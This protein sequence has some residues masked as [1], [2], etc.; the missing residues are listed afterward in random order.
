MVIPSFTS[1]LDCLISLWFGILLVTTAAT[2][3]GYFDCRRPG[4]NLCI[5]NNGVCNTKGACDCPTGWSG[6]M[7]HVDNANISSP[8]IQP[9]SD[10]G[11]CVTE[12]GA[13]V[14]KCN[15][16]RVDILPNCVVL[17]YVV[18]CDSS[19]M[20][21][22]IYPLGVFGG[23]IFV[24]GHQS[25]CQIPSNN[26]LFIFHTDT[27]CGNAISRVEGNK[28]RFS[29]VIYIQYDQA[30]LSSIDEV[31]EVVCVIPGPTVGTVTSVK[32]G[33]LPEGSAVVNGPGTYAVT[34]GGDLNPLRLSVKKGGSQVTD[35]T[36]IKIGTV[37]HL[38]LN[39]FPESDFED[40]LVKSLTVENNKAGEELKTVP[41]IS[42]G[43]HLGGDVIPEGVRQVGSL[44]TDFTFTA[45]KFTN[46]QDIKIKFDVK[47][48][49]KGDT[50]GCTAT[51][52]KRRKRDV[53]SSDTKTIEVVMNI[54]SNTGNVKQDDTINTDNGRKEPSGIDADS[55]NN[56]GGVRP[57]DDTKAKDDDL[58]F[59]FL[60]LSGGVL[61]GVVAISVLI[62]IVVIIVVVFTWRVLYRRKDVKKSENIS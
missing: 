29:R 42:N 58:G 53:G 37:L 54:W 60:G 4:Q 18:N 38:E 46:S 52:G 55:N 2:E 41:I 14:C 28:T 50:S 20:F 33:S 21:L 7:C 16:E 36:P 59:S 13:L 1:P 32:L 48:C 35:N 44:K 61:A 26:I 49:V 45:I 22:K 31:V 51:C 57:E 17:R 3:T 5:A 15:A 23:F 8:C 47:M 11:V 24:K 39:V 30:F 27:D 19:S 9:C 34:A 10:N 6:F 62:V 12:D 43:C 56:N 40:F 25:S